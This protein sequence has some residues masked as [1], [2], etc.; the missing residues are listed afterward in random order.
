MTR[1]PTNQVTAYLLAC[2]VLATLAAASTLHARIACAASAEIL[3]IDDDLRAEMQKEK[4]K[5]SRAA[6]ANDGGNG[7]DQNGCGQVDIGNSGNAAGG[8][9]AIQK[10]NP[11]DQTVIVTGPV[12]NMANCK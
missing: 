10:I 2:A 1:N 12:I 5:Q 3:D 11:K 7:G 9:S 4:L 8:N 6:Q